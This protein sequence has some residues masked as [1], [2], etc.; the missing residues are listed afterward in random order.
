MP[1][2]STRRR[3]ARHLPLPRAGDPTWR[4]LLAHLDNDA[5]RVI[6]LLAAMLGKRDQWLR[7]LGVAQAD[8][9]RQRLEETLRHEIGGELEHVHAMFAP[10]VMAMLV[11]C[12]AYAAA[13]L[14]RDGTDE[15]LA[16]ALVRCAAAGGV[17][18]AQWS[19]S[20]TGARWRTG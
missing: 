16:A 9:L 17:P 8:P 5:Q 18:P 13:N 20:P 2:S 15:A 11:R 1:S 6:A 12:E 4:A 7:H 3:R 10:D 19:I 14:E